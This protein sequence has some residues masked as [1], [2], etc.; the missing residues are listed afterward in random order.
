MFLAAHVQHKVF[1][2]RK[3]CVAERFRVTVAWLFQ[4]ARETYTGVLPSST[5]AVQR[6]DGSPMGKR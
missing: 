2:G 4:Q 6:Y 5:S 3:V 1:A